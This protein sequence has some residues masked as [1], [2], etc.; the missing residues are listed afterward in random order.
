MKKQ[1][2]KILFK[3][4]L[5]KIYISRTIGW[6]SIA[7]SVMLVFLVLERLSSLGVIESDLGN[8]LFIVVI[9]WFCLLVFLGW[10]EVEKIKAPHVESIKMIELNPPMN[11]MYKGIGRIEKK[12]EDLEE[13]IKEIKKR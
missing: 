12:L 2:K 4:V 6:M 9:S 11:Y 8:S 1:L 3:L 13:E 7:N 10:V 5:M